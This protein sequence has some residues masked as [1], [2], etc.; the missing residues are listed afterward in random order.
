MHA[1]KRRAFS[2]LK[3]ADL[4]YLLCVDACNDDDNNRGTRTRRIFLHFF[5]TDGAPQPR[6]Y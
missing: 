6:D 1:E 3:V 4:V 5:F 2:V